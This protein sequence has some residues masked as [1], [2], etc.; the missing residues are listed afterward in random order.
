MRWKLLLIICLFILAGCAEQ[1]IVDNRTT[2]AE[3]TAEPT[4]LTADDIFLEA[5]WKS[6]IPCNG[7]E[8]A[9]MHMKVKLG[10]KQQKYVCTSRVDED[11]SE[12]QTLVQ[13]VIQNIYLGKR[14]VF[15]NHTV[16]LCCR[17][18]GKEICVQ[19]TL[20]Q[21][22]EEPPKLIEKDVLEIDFSLTEDETKYFN[23]T[24][25]ENGEYEI[26]VNTQCKECNDNYFDFEI[27]SSEECL[28]KLNNTYYQYVFEI[29]HKRTLITHLALPQTT[30]LCIA[31]SH[32]DEEDVNV[33]K[34]LLVHGEWWE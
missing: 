7:I 28:K 33:T 32:D 16:L 15:Q 9:D 27:L 26:Y 2:E 17:L 14:N 1:Q 10:P 18:G 8:N 22:C 19:D 20:I 13:D 25:N 24:A 5:R 23:F 12:N 6:N 3:E 4:V 11:P 30:D 31:V 21:L 34:H 29:E